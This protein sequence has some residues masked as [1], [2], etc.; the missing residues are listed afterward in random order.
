MKSKRRKR[1]SSTWNL[2]IKLEVKRRQ[3]QQRRPRGNNKFNG[4]A[5]RNLERPGSH[6]VLPLELSRPC[7]KWACEQPVSFA[8]PFPTSKF[9]RPQYETFCNPSNYLYSFKKRLIIG[10]IW[11]FELLKSEHFLNKFWGL[12]L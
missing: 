7:F 11:Y 9:K 10:I 6:L 5:K 8:L 12:K 3:R 2:L 4:I 1:D